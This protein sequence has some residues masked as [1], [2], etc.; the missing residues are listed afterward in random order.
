MFHKI[1]FVFFLLLFVLGGIYLTRF[2]KTGDLRNQYRRYGLTESEM[3][4]EGVEKMWG[5]QGLI[6]Y[7]VEFPFLN[8]PNHADKMTFSIQDA[9][10][11][12]SLSHLTLNVKEAMKK[13]HGDDLSQ[14]LESYIPYSDFFDKFLTS[15]SVMGIDE[16]V[17]DIMVNSTYSDIKTMRF[18]VEASQADKPTLTMSGVIHVPVPGTRQLSDLWQGS[19]ESMD[20]KV[21][22]HSLL[23]RYMDYAKSRQS[24]F[25][26]D[27]KQ[28]YIKLKNL[29]KKLPKINQILR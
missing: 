21:Q 23:Q 7:Q 2:S 12:L 14:D 25:S 13:I 24:T 27:L 18:T 28:G 4:Y 6:Y 22:D 9:T 20:L 1:A 26:Q 29:P 17:G 3:H 10:A 19:L 16:F 15:L 11:K 5:E 8:V